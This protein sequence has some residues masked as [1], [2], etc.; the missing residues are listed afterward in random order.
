MERTLVDVLDRPD[1]GGGW[2]EVWRSLESVAYFDLAAVVEYARLLGSAT[3]AA[4]VGFFLEQHRDMLMVD[5]RHLDQ[6]RD[7]A[8]RQP[9]Y[10]DRGESSKG[11]M[12]KGWNLIVPLAVMDRTWEEAL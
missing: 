10:M 12:V 7:Y 11:V 8:P 6:L 1:L 5:A 9:H 2:E 4:K 3:T